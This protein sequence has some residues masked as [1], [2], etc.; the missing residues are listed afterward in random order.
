MDAVGVEG[1]GV[2]AGAC[3]HLL[4][5]GL[6]LTHPPTAAAGQAALGVDRFQHLGRAFFQQSFLD[7]EE[8]RHLGVRGVWVRERPKGRGGGSE[9]EAQGE[10]CVGEGER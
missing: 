7:V 8:L 2:Q 10:G 4:P 5:L 1:G 6:S 3:P 9:G